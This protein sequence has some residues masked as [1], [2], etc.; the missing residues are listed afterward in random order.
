MPPPQNYRLEKTAFKAMIFQE[1]DDHY[2]YSKDKTYAE[3]L[4]A[5]FFLINQVYNTTPSTKLDRTIFN[6]RKHIYWLI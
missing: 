5:A 2:S 1:A 3:R 6:K 4:N